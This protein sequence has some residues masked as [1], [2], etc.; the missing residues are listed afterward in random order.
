MFVPK[1]TIIELLSEGNNLKKKKKNDE[2]S[3][4]IAVSGE[5][6]ENSYTASRRNYTDLRRDLSA[7]YLLN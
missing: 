5:S 2:F 1:T 3:A 7:I 4:E 6:G